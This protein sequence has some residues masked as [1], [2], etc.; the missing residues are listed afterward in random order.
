VRP[1]LPALALLLLAA[2][3]GAG[4]G[5]RLDALPA[6][7][8]AAPGSLSPGA[9]FACLAEKGLALVVA[10]RGGPA[11]GFPE[12][13]LETLTY[14]TSR[15]VRALHVD[16]ARTGDGSLMLARAAPLETLSDGEGMIADQS[17]AD[18]R[19][20]R[21]KDARGQ[22]TP[23]GLASLASALDATRAGTLLLLE[24]QPGVSLAHLA[25]TVELAGAADRVVVILADAEAAAELGRQ[26][27]ALYLALRVHRPEDLSTVLFEGV[28]PTHVIALVSP[29]DPAAGPMIDALRRDGMAMMADAPENP[30]AARSLVDRGLRMLISDLP[31]T[32]ASGLGRDPGPCLAP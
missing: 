4:A 22:L 2:C 5:K 25:Q 20:I 32:L 23:F 16:V 17:Y 18:L 12:N 29:A 3:G 14:A 6:A 26:Y 7:P 31:T 28:P 19:V 13:A 9:L 30:A 21:L 15:G 24:P 1:V 27:P 11:P 8:V 10:R